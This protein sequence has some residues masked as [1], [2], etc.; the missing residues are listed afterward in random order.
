MAYAN[1]KDTDQPVDP[2]SLISIFVIHFKDSTG[3]RSGSVVERPTPERE[4]GSSIPTAAVLCP[5]TR[6]FIPRKYWLITQEVVAL[7]RHDWKIV[8]WDVKPQHRQTNKDSTFPV[9][10]TPTNS[11]LASFWCWAGCFES[12]LVA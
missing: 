5:W 7:S 10:A 12:Y 8:D 6:H 2:C 4:V 1:N 11:T 3:E 9:D